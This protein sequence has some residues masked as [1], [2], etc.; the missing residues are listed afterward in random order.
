M[1]NKFWIALPVFLAA[2]IFLLSYT[3]K[4]ILAPSPLKAASPVIQ[5]IESQYKMTDGLIVSYA[6]T[7][8]Q[9]LS[10]SVGLYMDYLLLTKDR[11]RFYSLFQALQ[12]ELTVREGDYIFIK[13]EKG[14]DVHVNALIDDLRIFEAL[15]K[16]SHLFHYPPYEAFAKQLIHGEQKYG[17][18]ESLPVDFFDFKTKRQADTLHLSYY[19]VLAMQ[20][21]HF[22]R[23]AFAPLEHVKA[24][25]FFPEVYRNGAYETSGNEV[26][27]IDQLLIAISYTELLEKKENHFDRFLK[28]ELQT[29]DQIYARYNRKTEVNMGENESTAV[30]ALLVQYF[31]LTKQTENKNWVLGKLKQMNTQNAQETHFFDYI[32]KELILTRER[33]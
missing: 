29:K 2:M 27:M 16:A 6:Q 28:Q 9:K 5:H 1:K 23:E 33:L 13:W 7:N 21:A 4:S 22:K 25:P 26:N 17:M 32:H 15:Q 19:K 3:E 20:N 8:T 14:A 11:E 24:E 31:E 18:R 12:Q 30:Y 10:E